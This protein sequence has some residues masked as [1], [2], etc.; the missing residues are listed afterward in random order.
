MKKNPVMEAVPN[1]Q[2]LH[3]QSNRHNIVTIWY[4]DQESGVDGLGEKL[5]GTVISCI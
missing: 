1:N 4:L 5:P 2:K 3:F